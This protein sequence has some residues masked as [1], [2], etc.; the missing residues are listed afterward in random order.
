MPI[1]IHS[2]ASTL[3]QDTALLHQEA[4]NFLYPHLSNIQSYND[5]AK[6]IRA[7]YGFY[8]P[9]EQQVGNY[10]STSDLADISERSQALLILKDLQSLPVEPGKLP[11]CFS[12]PQIQS[13][14]QAFGALYVMEGS[15]LGGRMISKMLKKNKLLVFDETNLNFFNG[16]GDQT[17]EK[18]ISFLEAINRQTETEPIIATANETFLLFGKWLKQVFDNA[19]TIYE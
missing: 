5:Y 17:G 9:L 16:Y 8:F 4:E 15:T 18:W 13:R 3:K 7:F 1:T 12:L 2:V 14:A 11:I 19:G 6:I 10:I